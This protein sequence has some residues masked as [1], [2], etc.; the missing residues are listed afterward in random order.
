MT[1]ATDREPTRGRGVRI[2]GPV[3]PG[4]ADAC[5]AILRALTDWFGIESALVQYIKD[6]AELPTFLAVESG[7]DGEGALVGF[8]AVREHFPT[9][10]EI[11]V[12]GVRPEHHG[13]GIG[14]ALV[15]AAGAWLRDRG[16]RLLQ[17][18]T[19]GP[20]RTDDTAYAK[21]RAFYQA[22]GF[23]PL[24]EIPTL[25]NERNP[26]LILVKPLDRA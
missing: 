26:C 5:E 17:V 24:E 18:K 20:S 8:L 23:L 1:P 13:R 25:W 6:V 10:A 21:T 15:T 7:S 3:L 16:V 9:A 22:V 12:M 2:E 11:H 14:R 4:P 19:V